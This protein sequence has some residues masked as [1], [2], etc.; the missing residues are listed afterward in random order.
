MSGSAKK[1]RVW[2]QH[3]KGPDDMLGVMQGAKADVQ[4]RA[5]QKWGVGVTITVAPN[6]VEVTA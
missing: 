6:F 4:K 5:E 1:W 3:A 2:R